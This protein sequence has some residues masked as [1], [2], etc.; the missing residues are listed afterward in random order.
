MTPEQY[1]LY[2]GMQRLFRLMGTGGNAWTGVRATTVGN[3]SPT[4]ASLASRT[5]RFLENNRVAERSSLPAIPVYTAP[6]WGLAAIGV[7][8]QPGDIYTNG[9]IAFSVTGLPD[10]SQGFQVIPAAALPLIE[11]PGYE[12]AAG[13]PLLDNDG[14]TLL[15]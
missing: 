2:T 10:T 6:W 15:G 5:I 13:L 3:G 9:T 14:N 12:G 1:R 7:D 8:V 4:F 11:V